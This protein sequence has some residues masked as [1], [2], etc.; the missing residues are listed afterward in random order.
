MVAKHSARNYTIPRAI[1]L[2]AAL[3]CRCCRDLMNS[4]HIWRDSLRLLRLPGSRFSTLC[5]SWA[6]VV[7]SALAISSIAVKDGL[8]LPLS[9]RLM[10]LGWYPLSKASVSCVRP[11]SSLRVIRTRA[12]A[13]FSRAPRS[14]RL[15]GDMIDRLDRGPS[16]Y[17]MPQTILSPSI[18]ANDP[19][20][21]DVWNQHQRQE[22][23]TRTKLWLDPFQTGRRAVGRD[24]LWS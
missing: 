17:I 21:H 3:E 12:K 22:S 6:P 1:V 20:Y 16:H 15:P 7:S 18:E 8:F 9:K 24:I 23:L 4:C 14:V 5:T 10:Y 19:A 13:L 2:R 11:R